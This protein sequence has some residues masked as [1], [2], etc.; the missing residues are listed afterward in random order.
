MDWTEPEKEDNA[1]EKISRGMDAITC[2]YSTFDIDE[3]AIAAIENKYPVAE[4]PERLNSTEEVKEIQ[5][6]IKEIKAV[7]KPGIEAI[8]PVKSAA[9]KLHKR[10]KSVENTFLERKR[11]VLDPHAALLKE[12]NERII[13]EQNE[14]EL[15]EKERTTSINK[16]I[17]AMKGV[18]SDLL[19]AESAVVDQTLLT[20][21]EDDLSWAEEFVTPAM[22]ARTAL[23]EQLEQLLTMRL[24]AENA[25]EQLAINAQLKK[26]EDEKRALAIAR[27]EIENEIKMIPVEMLESSS[28]DIERKIIDL[29]EFINSDN[30]SY[31]KPVIDQLSRIMV[32]AI[33]REKLAADQAAIAAEKTRLANEESD[34]QYAI[35]KIEKDKKAEVLRIEQE[36]QEKEE[37]ESAQAQADLIEAERVAESE[38]N[39][40]ANIRETVN[41]LA[42]YDGDLDRVVDDIIAGIFEH[43]KWV[44]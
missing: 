3:T 28:A 9:F 44:N 41:H 12:Y 39:R 35:A 7:F 2:D 6:K 14:A 31:I 29:K 26:D 42:G 21:R 23:I 43:L 30:D 20:V 25:A 27:Q 24:D 13:R 17:E 1:L 22:T 18:A 11:G 15:A 33:A 16:R 34:R 19:T 4:L 40:Q 8:T 36:K 37:R 10:I 5:V 38:K 32:S